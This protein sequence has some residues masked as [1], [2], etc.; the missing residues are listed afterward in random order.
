MK[1]FSLMKIIDYHVHIVNSGLTIKIFGQ[2]RNI[3]LLKNFR[4]YS[5]PITMYPS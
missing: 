3:Y 2:T 1:S 4:L 5:T